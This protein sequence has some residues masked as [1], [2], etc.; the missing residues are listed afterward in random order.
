MLWLNL[1]GT[2]QPFAHYYSQR[3]KGENLK[4]NCKNKLDK[5]RVIKKRKKEKRKK[6]KEKK[7]G[8]GKGMQGKGR[9]EKGSGK[10]A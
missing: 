10:H 5:D 3:D 8:E 9:E 4:D 1:T 6:K 7:G 2:A